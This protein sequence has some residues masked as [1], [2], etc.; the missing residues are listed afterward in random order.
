M[1][2]AGF[3]L[4]YDKSGSYDILRG[5]LAGERS[6]R[7]LTWNWQGLGAMQEHM[8][9]FLE[10]HDEQRIASP[11]FAGTPEKAWSALAFSMLFNTAPFMLYSG[12]EVG[13]DASEGHEGRT[14]IFE[15]SRPAGLDALWEYI[16]TGRGLSMERRHILSRYRELCR[17]AGLREYSEG[18]VWD[19]CYC[20]HGAFD[21][22]SQFAFARFAAGKAWAILCNFTSEPVSVPVVIPAALQAAAGIKNNEATL[23][24]APFDFGIARLL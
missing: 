8:L 9:N 20:Q 1:D 5:I 14:S 2:E 7:E 17:L 24:A 10:N 3:D 13:E 11:W 22:D 16:H 6:A 23:E 18:G 19:L 4:L 21:A 15:W 12:Q